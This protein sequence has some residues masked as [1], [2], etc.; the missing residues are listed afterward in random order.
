VVVSFTDIGGIFKMR[1]RWL[2]VLMIFVKLL[3]TTV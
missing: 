3:T 2:L 1:L